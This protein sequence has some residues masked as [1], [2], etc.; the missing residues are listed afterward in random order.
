MKKRLFTTMMLL[1]TLFCG[2]GFSSVWAEAKTYVLW[3]EGNTT[4]Y[5]L[6]GETEYSEGGTYNSQTITKVWSGSNYYKYREN[7]TVKSSCTT[8]VFENSLNGFEHCNNMFENFTALT[9]VTGLSNALKSNTWDAS[10]MF[11][12]CSELTTLDFTGVNTSTVTDMSS[13]FSD[14]SKLIS[15][16]LSMFNTSNVTDLGYMFKNCTSLATLDISSFNTAKVTSMSNMFYGC[17]KLTSLDL[18]FFNTAKV[19][20]MTYMFNNCK[21]LS[22]LDVTSFNTA[23]VT[24]MSYM[25]SQCNALTSLNLSSFDVSKVTNM[26]QMFY[27]DDH[28]VTIYS[29]RDWNHD[30]LN[31]SSKM[32]MYCSRLRGATISYSNSNVTA[33]YAN[34]TTGYFTSTGTAVMSFSPSTKTIN[35][36]DTFTLPTLSITPS[37]LTVTYSSSDETVATVDAST[38]AVTP[39][40]SGTTTITASFA[41]NGSYSANSA[42]YTLTVEAK[43]FGLYLCGVPMTSDYIVN[44]TELT[45]ALAGKLTAGTLSLTA[46]ADYNAL[47]LALDGAT[48]DSGNN[49][50]AALSNSETLSIVAT[51]SCEL[52]SSS[53][54]GTSLYN[55]GNLTFSG[56]GQMKVTGY[57]SGIENQAYFTMSGGTLDVSGSS[58]FYGGNTSVLT[59]TGGKLKATGSGRASIEILGQLTL[60][61]GVVITQPLGAVWNSTRHAVCDASGDFVKEQVV[62]SSGA[63]ACGLAYSAATAS[64]KYGV[65]PT[66]P[67]LTNPHGLP[68][69]YS[70]SNEAVATINASGVVTLVKPGD[71]TITATFAGNDSYIAG[72]ASYALTVAKGDASL[73][74]SPTTASV[75]FGET[76]TRPTLTAV[77]ESLKTGYQIEYSSSNEAVASLTGT[78]GEVVVNSKGTTIIKATFAGNDHYN[79]ADAQYT[80]TVSAAAA[81]LSFAET[82]CEGKVGMAF[83]SP[84]LTMTPSDL[85]V[86]YTSSDPTVATVVENTG[87]VMPNA[88]GTVTITATVNDAQY[89][90]TA[91][92]QLTISKNDSGLAFAST[93]ATTTYGDDFI[94][95]ALTNTHSLPVTYS[96]DNN[97]VAKVDLSTGGVTILKAG[98]ATITATF[99]GNMTYEPCSTSYLLT[100]EKAAATLSFE[101]TDVE[102]KVGDNISSP[103]LTIEPAGLTIKYSTSDRIV[104][105]VNY[106]GNV[107]ARKEGT[108]TITATVDD[109]RYAGTASYTVTI[110]KKAAGLAFPV[111][112]AE[113]VI[114]EAFT[115]PV[116]S[117]PNNL[118]VNYTSSNSAVATISYTNGTVTI[119]QPGSAVMTA[120]SEATNTYEA[121][122]ATYTLTVSKGTATLTF[123]SAVVDAKVGVDFTPTLTVDPEG[124]HVV[125]SCSNTD[126]ATVATDGKVTPHAEGEVM[127]TATVDDDCYEGSASYKM[128]IAKNENGLAFSAATATATMGETFTPPTLSNEHELPVIFSSSR[129]YVASVDADGN[130]K[131]NKA[132]ETVISAEFAGS[133][134]YGASTVSYTLTVSKGTATVSF[135]LTEVNAKV[136][137]DI[138]SPVPTTTPEGLFVKYSSSNTTLATVGEVTG[139]VTPKA[140]GEVTITATVEDDGYEGSASYTLKISKNEN[141][142]A[143]SAATATA[144]YGISFTPPTLTNQY[145]LPVTYESSKTEVATV[146][147]DGKVTVLKTGETTISAKFVGDDTYEASTVS[148]ILTVKK[149]AA[150]LTFEKT[151]IDAEVG[152]V[153]TP[154]L[155]VTPIGLKV[156]YTSSDTSVATVDASTGQLNPLKEGTATITATVDDNNYEGSAS[157]K[158]TVTKIEENDDDETSDD[159]QT[160]D[161]QQ[162]DDETSDD[163]QTPD[164]QQSDAE[165]PDVQQSDDQNSDDDQTPDDQQ[166]DDQTPDDQT[167][168]DQ[169]S[170][171]ET[172]DDQTPDDQQSDDQQS[173]DQTPDDDQTTDNDQTSDDDQT[174]GDQTID[175][176]TSDDSTPDD[177]TIKIGSA[178]QVPY[179]SEY[180]LDFTNLSELKAYV[181][182]GYDK[183]TG[184]IWLTRVKKV[185][186]MTGFL[187]MGDPGE[188]DIPATESVSDTYYKNMFKGTVEGTTIYTTEGAY[189]NY[190]LSSGDKGV[191]F[192]KVT[193]TEGVELKANRAYLPILADIPAV[194]GEGGIETIKVSSALQVPYFT[195]Q[196]LDFTNVEGVKAY[197]AT[198]YNY[199]SGTIWLTRVKKVPA[200]TGVLVIA[201]KSGEYNVPTVSVSSVFENMFAGSETAQTIQTTEQVG[202]I[203]Y[204]NY[205]LS[206]GAN[207]VGFYK[208]TKE[209]GVKMSANRSY[210]QIPKRESVLGVRGKSE[211]S[212]WCKISISEED[213][214][215]IALP[216]FSDTTGIESGFTNDIQQ[217]DEWFD[218]QGRRLPIKPSQCGL[219]IC[220]GKKV[221]IK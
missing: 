14:C 81:T 221:V 68:V 138:D 217:Q 166:S 37:G 197:T 1:T 198:G 25:F 36:G 77:P 186:A 26:T 175:D 112:T 209:D 173:D 51:G 190:Y 61:E 191:G 97:A 22:S 113:A 210:L 154:L 171:D 39:L 174:S 114:G 35:V 200:Q 167:T 133:D 152:G 30:G 18:S 220:N 44:N 122:S 205:Y 60:G 70:S 5:F 123:A 110:T 184:T 199:S 10:S 111:A 153:L 83:Q 165:T 82:A 107:T 202:G 23:E 89:A 151:E 53:S 103:S 78:E 169:Q 128:N 194:G 34:P 162:S 33:E 32:F 161:V 177:V 160:P 65:T 181:A 108:A 142:L 196:S 12:K 104:A 187:L 76:L 204:V 125:Y 164:V 132:G 87:V 40:H 203:N 96:S 29:N 140:V 215:V 73:T 163:D 207:G 130:V 115:A 17:E 72:S 120:S 158:V 11:Y 109:P 62:I 90:G 80:L 46:N 201:E 185:P 117:N 57:S 124:L 19:T 69:T 206:N 16:D 3:C 20:T 168:D 27:Y 6:Y 15:L 208:V 21:L 75:I 66:L 91:S 48:L 38:G 172:P 159:D 4:L 54:I 135:S 85:T 136:G 139:K 7:S 218:L 144:T 86:K 150:T 50:S 100:V 94:P 176:Q 126:L 31:Y 2:A 145:V 67:T 45:T 79:A 127:I 188:Y 148:Y 213:D 147:S 183:A 192:Y 149:G 93:T 214:D 47:T 58:G 180:N 178:R 28:L 146:D 71:A 211:A 141:G 49:N 179:C 137:I 131:L 105:L 8:A 157:Y 13:M 52:K 119:H 59:M 116:L 56:T 195:S 42:S 95:P 189:T 106:A 101:Q 43:T 216:V 24:D 63:T 41:G 212:A 182:T 64:V 155:T 74:Y 92:Y 193:K 98:T 219:Y 134:T 102:A 143:F 121:G 84:T 118:S 99:A 156:T 88:E 9:S 170:G 129:P 55:N